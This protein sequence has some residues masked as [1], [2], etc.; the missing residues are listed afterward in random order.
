MN[1]GGGDRLL[2]KSPKS[3]LRMVSK[4]GMKEYEE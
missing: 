4:A 3:N 2:K 1:Q